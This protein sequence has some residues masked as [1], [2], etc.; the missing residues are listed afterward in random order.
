MPG[1]NVSPFTSIERD[2]IRREF[3]KHFG[4]YPKLAH[5][6]LLRT[7][8][9]GPKANLPKVPKAM[10]GLVEVGLVKIPSRPQPAFVALAHFTAAGLTAMRELL[11][12]RRSMNPQQFAHLRHE[13]GLDQVGEPAEQ[14]LG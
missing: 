2:L 1:S 13:L 6:M 7:W 10:A 12:D 9:S 14:E 11:Q 4:S 5:G 3:C 8:R